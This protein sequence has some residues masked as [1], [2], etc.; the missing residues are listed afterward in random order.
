LSRNLMPVIGHIFPKKMFPR[1][2]D[3]GFGY[4]WARRGVGWQRGQV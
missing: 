3:G 2:R 4:Q 1:A